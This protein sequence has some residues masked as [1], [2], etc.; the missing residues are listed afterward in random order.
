[1]HNQP[2]ADEFAGNTKGEIVTEAKMDRRTFYW[3][4]FGVFT[5]VSVIVNAWHAGVKA[6]LHFTALH[7]RVP[8]LWEAWKVGTDQPPTWFTLGAVALGALMP[9]ALA[10]GSHALANPRPDISKTRMW[11]NGILTGLTVLGAF[12]LSFLAM[13]DMGMM[14]LG[15]NPWAAAIVPI[16]VDIAIVS[17]LAELVAR[18]PALTETAVRNRV[19]EQV[20]RF[21][22][23]LDAVQERIEGRLSA[24]LGTLQNHLQERFDTNLGMVQE[25]LQGQ[26]QASVDTVQEHLQERLSAELGAVQERLESRPAVTHSGVTRE[27]A[28]PN[29]GPVSVREPLTNTPD[30]LAAALV[31]SGGLGTQTAEMIQRVLTA[32]EN[33]KLSSAKIAEQITA[34]LPKNESVSKSTVHR[35]LTAARE[36]DAQLDAADDQEHNNHELV[37]V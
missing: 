34:E 27:A 31:A 4:W 2:L 10:F 37:A 28:R 8:T 36:L 20:E 35:I 7:D 6:P 14:L 5:A 9:I 26:F 11:A 16:A 12:I 32:A 17:A 18:S 33:T 21:E 13:Q 3:V 29:P 24:E 25:Q 19:S 15:L 23:S 22:A 30:A 1:M